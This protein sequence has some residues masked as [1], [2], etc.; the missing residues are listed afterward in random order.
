MSHPRRPAFE[1]MTSGVA[2]GSQAIAAGESL[3]T[4]MEY[5]TIILDPEA[6]RRPMG[7]APMA[8]S[9]VRAAVA[10]GAAAVA[11]RAVRG[12]ERWAGPRTPVAVKAPEFRVVDTDT[13]APTAPATTYTAAVAALRAMTPAARSKLRV[14]GAHERMR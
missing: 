14:I 10:M 8:G 11:P 12:E 6:R 4:T 5:E 1:K 9:I 7:T 2:L 13:L 3:D